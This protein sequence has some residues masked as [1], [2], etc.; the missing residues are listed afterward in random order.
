MLLKLETK[1]VELP[2]EEKDSIKPLKLFAQISHIRDK[3]KG[4]ILQASELKIRDME[5]VKADLIG[6]A[7]VEVYEEV[8]VGQLSIIAA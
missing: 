7:T 8:S 2:G 6:A 1:A 5:T 3:E 4:V